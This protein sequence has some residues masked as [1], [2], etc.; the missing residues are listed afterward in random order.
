MVCPC[1]SISSA[2]KRK[3]G[4]EWKTRGSEGCYLLDGIRL[5][6]SR[7]EREEVELI[8]PIFPTGGMFTLVEILVLSI[9]F[10]CN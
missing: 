9:E 8:R 10:R 4:L 2:L 5:K 3:R 1:W 7:A 6:V